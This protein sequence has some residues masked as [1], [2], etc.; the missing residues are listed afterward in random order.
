MLS[1]NITRYGVAIFH[2]N[3]IIKKGMNPH[4]VY[5]LDKVTTFIS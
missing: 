3:I 5:N 2:T 1:S 4:P